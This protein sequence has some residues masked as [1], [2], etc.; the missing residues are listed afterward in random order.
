[1]A[2]RQPFP[3]SLWERYTLTNHAIIHVSEKGVLHKETNKIWCEGEAL[4][5]NGNII[6][7]VIKMVQYRTKIEEESY[8]ISNK[9]VE[10]VNSHVKLPVECSV[11]RGGCLG[12]KTY[13]WNAPSNQCPLVKINTGKSTVKA[14][15]YSNTEQNTFLRLL[16]HHHHQL[17]VPQAV[18]STQSTKICT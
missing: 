14:S 3:K 8:L 18:S 17:V 10:V 16:T 4:K 7:G 13:L 12:K 1:M 15:G 5:I 2:V 11:E 6:D 9:R